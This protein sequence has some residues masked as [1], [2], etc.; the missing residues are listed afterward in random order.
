[1]AAPG[2][3]TSPCGDIAAAW[4]R[5]HV[6]DGWSNLL[7][8]LHP[9]LGHK[10]VRYGEFIDATYGTFLVRPDAVPGDAVRVPLQDVAY[11]VTAPLFATS[12]VG[13][14]LWPTLVAPCASQRTSL[15]GYVAVFD[16]GVVRRVGCTRGWQTIR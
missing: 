1:M 13:L 2:H 11:R 7:D 12:S 15:V 9:Y 6:A 3:T 5:Q 8:P 14:L 16:P 10:I 4:Q